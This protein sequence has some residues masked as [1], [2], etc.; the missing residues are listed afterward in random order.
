[1]RRTPAAL[2]AA[3]LSLTALA[4]CA[5]NHNPEAIVGSWKV[6]LRPTPDSP[7]YFQQFIVDQVVTDPADGATEIVGTFYG[8]P[9]E[10]GR[11]NTDWDA[12][13]F[14]FVTHD[15]SGAYNHSGVLRAGRLHGLSHSLARDSLWV[16]TA[17]PK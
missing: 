16:W 7:P 13:H 6:D 11:I 1:M 8:S 3:S 5:T 2:F 9:I 4:G 15:N 12:L 10:E 17:T 14:A